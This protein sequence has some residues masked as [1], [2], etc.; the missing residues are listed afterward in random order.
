MLDI[1]TNCCIEKS[2]IFDVYP[3]KAF[4]LKIAALRHSSNDLSLFMFDCIKAIELILAISILFVTPKA[5]PT[6]PKNALLRHFKQNKSNGFA[7][8]H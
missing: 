8:P 7:E 6:I 2:T 5:E 1:V 4:F 3:F